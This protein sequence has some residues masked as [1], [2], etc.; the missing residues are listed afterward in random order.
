MAVV[1][2]E[3]LVE[4]L[5]RRLRTS[6]PQPPRA[7]VAAALAMA[8]DP[9]LKASKACD[10]AG[11]PKGGA[12]SRVAEYHKRINSEGMLAVFAPP[13]A[14]ELPPPIDWVSRAAANLKERY[15]QLQPPSCRTCGNHCEL[16]HFLC[17]KRTTFCGECQTSPF[18]SSVYWVSAGCSD[19]CVEKYGGKYAL[20]HACTSETA[21]VEWDSAADCTSVCR[22]SFTLEDIGV[23]TPEQRDAYFETLDVHNDIDAEANEVRCPDANRDSGV[24]EGYTDAGEVQIAKALLLPSHLPDP[25]KKGAYTGPTDDYFS[26]LLVSNEWIAS[27]APNIWRLNV[28]PLRVSDDGKHATRRLFAIMKVDED[29][30]DLEDD[31]EWTNDYVYEEV[32]YDFPNLDSRDIFAR[33]RHMD[34]MRQR[35]MACIRVLDG[36]AHV[37]Y[38]ERKSQLASERLL[39]AS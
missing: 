2:D 10:D 11:V 30:R 16:V 28:M 34:R 36:D 4:E 14:P 37:E 22:G 18:P 19:A 15:P 17:Q 32:E 21:R 26:R 13:P 9:T 33:Q 3:Q 23:E 5:Q 29:E 31:D 7:S 1:T 20:C 27:N 39:S 25:K 6:G 12:R 8:R 38:R 35:E 24:P